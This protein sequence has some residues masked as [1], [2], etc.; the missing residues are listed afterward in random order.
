[1]YTAV[2]RVKSILTELNSCTGNCVARGKKKKKIY[3]TACAYFN[4]IFCGH[5]RKTYLKRSGITRSP[6]N[7]SYTYMYVFVLFVTNSFNSA[8][9]VMSNAMPV[10]IWF[11]VLF[12]LPVIQ[13]SKSHKVCTF[14]IFIHSEKVSLTEIYVWTV[15][16]LRAVQ[17]MTAVITTC[18]QFC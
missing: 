3:S 16:T 18:W 7:Y 8:S 2:H 1:M 13:E 10:E 5:R 15:S 6:F 4:F 14:E 12:K 17:H 11:K 9:S